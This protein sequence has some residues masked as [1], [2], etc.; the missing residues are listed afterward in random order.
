[1][2][3][4]IKPLSN[5]LTLFL[6]EQQSTMALDITAGHVERATFHTVNSFSQPYYSSVTEQAPVDVLLF[7]GLYHN[8]AHI[9]ASQKL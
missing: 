2:F 3:D 1:M 9:I 7:M 4:I 6:M 8:K 5:R